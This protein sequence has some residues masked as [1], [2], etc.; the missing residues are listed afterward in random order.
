[1]TLR[2]RLTLFTIFWFIFILIL[3]N[4][5]VYFFVIRI[6]TGSEEQLIANK[7]NLII[8]HIRSDPE[9]LAA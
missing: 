5:F 6:S 8:E 9:P 7:V 3:F 1:M 2:K 4:I